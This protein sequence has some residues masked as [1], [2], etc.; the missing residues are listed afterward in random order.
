MIKTE[1][2]DR[3]LFTAVAA[4]LL[5]AVA[6]PKAFADII[7]YA[8]VVVLIPFAATLGV[9]AGLPPERTS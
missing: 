7:E 4:I 6:A 1:K 8:L 3:R 2:P 5:I 9:N